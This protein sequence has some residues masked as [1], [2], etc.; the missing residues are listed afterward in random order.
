MIL[1]YK[2]YYIPFFLL[3]VVHVACQHAAEEEIEIK[4]RAQVK[5]ANIRIQE[6]AAQVHLTGTSLYLQRNVITAPVPAYIT[7]VHAKLGDRV[8]KGTM[9]YEL[10]TKERRAIGNQQISSDTALGSFGILMIKAPANGVIST[11]DKQQVGD[12]VL[13][14]ATLCTIAESKHIVFQ[15]N[16]PYEYHRYA[17]PHSLCGIILPDKRRLTGEIITPLAIMNAQAQTETYLVKPSAA[18]A[19][20]E[21]LIATI[22]LTTVRRNSVQVLPKSCVQT[23]EIMK[24]FW[25]MK[26]ISDSL[27]VKV[28]VQ[29][30]IQNDSLAE[31]ISPVFDVRDRIITSGGYGLADTALVNIIK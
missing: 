25:V 28:P 11:L 1:K 2:A 29:I 5:I 13:E 3:A 15:L 18:V 24:N 10:E 7:R 14:G 26:L 16:V 23:D 9:L 4:P 20:P 6:M 8:L 31:I 27:A 22:S 30:G 12:Y 21:N 19:L 17:A